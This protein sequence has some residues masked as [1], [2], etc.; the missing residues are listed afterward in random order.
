V[1]LLVA[2]EALVPSAE[3]GDVE[4]K[5]VDVGA[6][7]VAE[8]CRNELHVDAGR[9]RHTGIATGQNGWPHTSE[10]RPAL[11]VT[12]QVVVNDRCED[13]NVKVPDRRQNGGVDGVEPTD[14]VVEARRHEEK[15]RLPTGARRGKGADLNCEPLFG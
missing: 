15:S 2:N 1:E 13:Y 9:E 5:G 10:Q 4:R 7:E 12:R 6:K 14:E 11:G 3:G 8:S